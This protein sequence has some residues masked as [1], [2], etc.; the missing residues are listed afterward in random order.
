MAD[1]K[2]PWDGWQE[3]YKTMDDQAEFF[4]LKFGHDDDIK[5]PEV[6]ALKEGFKKFA[7]PG[8]GE[9]E[10]DEAMRLMESR[11]NTKTF[12]ELRDMVVEIDVDKNRKLSFLEWACAIYGKSWE[13]L[14][15]LKVVDPEEIARL[16]VIEAEKRKKHDEAQKAEDEKRVAE[17]RAKAEKAAAESSVEDAQRAK[18]ALEAELRRQEE[19]LKEKHA[20]EAAE[21]ARKEADAQSLRAAE[22]RREGVKGKVALFKYAATDRKDPTG[23]NANLIK[24]Q[25]AKRKLLKQQEIEALAKKKLADEETERKRQEAEEAHKRAMI[26][27]QEAKRAQ[28]VKE[29]AEAEAKRVEEEKRKLLESGDAKLRAAYEAKKKEEE[30]KSRIK[31]EQEE[32]K[33]QDGRAK[34]ASKATLWNNN[35]ASDVVKSVAGGGA[36]ANLKHGATVEKSGLAQANLLGSIKKGTSLHKTPGTMGATDELTDDQK[37]EFVAEQMKKRGESFS[38]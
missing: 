12:V 5:R 16:E 38:S 31:R 34:I 17:L 30:E 35:S 13:K 14:H 19:A 4:L 7:K 15:T 18:Q 22:L 36:G 23:E 8:K 6:M 21:R 9:L 20:K 26:A 11:N 28:E 37:A 1:T 24:D 25:A 32:K 27:E 10:E 2:T 33:R 29:A 3:K